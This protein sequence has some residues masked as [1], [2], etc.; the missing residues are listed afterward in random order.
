MTHFLPFQPSASVSTSVVC[1]IPTAVHR[2]DLQ[3]TPSRALP[4]LIFGVGSITHFAPFQPSAN[5]S[6]M[7]PLLT[8]CPTAVHARA[9]AHDTASSGGGCTTLVVPLGLGEDS[10]VHFV[11]FQFSASERGGRNAVGLKGTYSPTAVHDFTVGHDTP[12]N[13]LSSVQPGLY[14]GGPAEQAPPALGG[15][16]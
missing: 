13:S 14:G 10:I 8:Y 11:P 16:A 5:V 3:D 7:P 2:E 6:E 9:D 15:R 4:V 1:C 12:R